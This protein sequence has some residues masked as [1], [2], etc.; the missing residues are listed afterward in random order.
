MVIVHMNN[1]MKKIVL[2]LKTTFSITSICIILFL[3]NYYLF[4]LSSMTLC[5]ID[6]AFICSYISYSFYL[7]SA[8]NLVFEA[9]QKESTGHKG[10]IF[11]FIYSF[12]LVFALI[13]AENIKVICFMMYYYHLVLNILF[14]IIILI[15][16]YFL[17]QPVRSLLIPLMLLVPLIG[18]FI[19]DTILGQYQRNYMNNSIESI[20]ETEKQV[21]SVDKKL[22]SEF[23]KEI[24]NNDVSSLVSYGSTLSERCYSLQMDLEPCIPQKV[25][26]GKKK[27]ESMTSFLSV[28]ERYETMDIDVNKYL[29]FSQFSSDG[30]WY[31]GGD[32]L[33]GIVAYY[34][35]C[36][37]DDLKDCQRKASLEYY[38]KLDKWKK[39]ALIRCPRNGYSDDYQTY[40]YIVSLELYML[41]K[42]KSAGD[43]ISQDD[44]NRKL[45]KIEEDCH[46]H[47]QLSCD[48][49][50][51]LYLI[52]YCG[53]LSLSNRLFADEQAMQRILLIQGEQLGTLKNEEMTLSSLS[54]HEWD[55]TGLLAWQ[56]L[57]QNPLLNIWSKL[58]TK[59]ALFET[60]LRHEFN[61]SESSAL[62]NGYA[63]FVNQC[64]R[65]REKLH[66]NLELIQFIQQDHDTK[67]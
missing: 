60:I 55:R 41:H 27:F 61:E 58:L 59:R 50:A 3:G 65:S 11:Q 43:I 13:T 62:M 14:P 23:I 29:S 47:Y 63:Y 56:L 45:A 15:R 66:Q 38:N 42:M 26:D 9:I 37:I 7:F 40:S 31:Y 21:F 44:V 33:K 12:A 20:A 51:L 32:D 34:L 8:I 54:A 1:T 19:H 4:R 35:L 53:C 2:T 46:Y 16:T 22:Q 57:I 25:L 10:L 49:L 5:G 64:L 36:F 48:K 30:N 18:I 52:K 67:K 39:V 24:I 28:V 17:R 6:V